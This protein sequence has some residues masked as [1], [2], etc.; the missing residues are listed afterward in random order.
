MNFYQKA[1]PQRRYAIRKTSA[2]VGSVLIGFFFLAGNMQSV[3]AA[4]QEVEA[5]T[6]LV[7]Q[8]STAEEPSSFESK[9]SEA[10]T[11]QLNSE[12]VNSKIPVSENTLDKENTIAITENPQLDSLGSEE[13]KKAI[14]ET[15]APNYYE[16]ERYQL[17]QTEVLVKKDEKVQLKLTNITTNEEVKEIN[18]YVRTD[19]PQTEVYN[20]EETIIGEDKK[21]LLRL[22][23]DGTVTSLNTH[24]KSQTVELW[25]EHNKHLYRA[26]VK[27]PG[28]EEMEA[29]QQ[30]RK[31]NAKADEIVKA[32]ENLSDVEKAKAAHDWLVDNVQYVDRPGKDQSA[33][34]ALVENKTVCAGYA[35]AF[36]LLMD[37]MGIPCHTKQGGIV[38]SQNHLW[39]M[40][41]LD[42][43]WYHVDAT[44]DDLGHTHLN[45]HR[46]EYFL[47]SDKDF[48][49]T[50]VVKRK[51]HKAHEDN[52]GE[53]YRFYGFEHEGLLKDKN[54]KVVKQGV[55]AKNIEEVSE[56][57]ER[58]YHKIAFKETSAV[59]ELLVPSSEPEANIHSRLA[60]ILT[61]TRFE[62]QKTSYGDYIFYRFNVKLYPRWNDR[63]NEPELKIDSLEANAPD[64]TEKMSSVLV[65][66][67][68]SVELSKSNFTVTGARLSEV[69]KVGNNGKVYR[70]KL[71]TPRTIV[72]GDVEISVNKRGYHREQAPSK[73]A[74]QVNR[75]SIPS[76]SFKAMGE[77]EGMLINV[78]SGME[79]RLNYGAWK[80]ISS[81]SV[82]LNNIG[83]AD[84][85][86]RVAETKN[87]Y[88]SPVQRLIVQKNSNVKASSKD[89]KIIG[90]NRSM[91]YR[92]KN[93]NQWFDCQGNCIT[94]LVNGEYEIRTKANANYLA[95]EITIVNLTN[96]VAETEEALAKQQAKAQEIQRKAEE[97]QAKREQKNLAQE[98]KSKQTERTRKKRH[99]ESEQQTVEAQKQNNELAKAKAAEKVTETKW[100]QGVNVEDHEFV[101]ITETDKD[102]E[103]FVTKQSAG[104]GWYD[105]NKNGH[106][107][108]DLCAGAVA[109]NMLHWW[110]D[111][112]KDYIERYLRENNNNGT[113]TIQ[114][115]KF[116]FRE[117]RQVYTGDNGYRDQ[118]RFFDI[119]KQAFP[120]SSVWTNKILD[121]YINGY[122]Y[123]QSS[124]MQNPP[125]E[126]EKLTS[127]INFFRNVFGGTPL[128]NYERVHDHDQ[129]SQSIKTALEQG[130]AIGVAYYHNPDATGHIVTAWGA[131]FD[132]SGKV[133][134]IYVSD[135]DDGGE[136]VPGEANGQVGLRRYRVEEHEG[137]LKLTS[138][139]QK[140]FGSYIGFI[141]TLSQGTE[142]WKEYFKDEE[143]KT[144]KLV[145]PEEA[146]AKPE[147]SEMDILRAEAERKAQEEQAKR[148]RA[149]AEEKARQEEAKRKQEEIAKQAKA[150][151]E[152]ERKAQEEQARRDR[153]LAEEQAKR[154]QEEKAKQVE[155]QRQAEAER[156]AE[157]ERQAEAQRQAEV[158]RKAQEEQAKREQEEKA[159]QVEAKRQAEAKRKAQEEQAQRDRAFAEEKARQEQVK[160]EQEEKAKQVE[161]QRQAEAERKT[162]EE[163][164]KRDRA[165]AEEKTRQEEAKRKQEEIAKQAEA[166]RKAQEE[167]AKREAE[168]KAKEEKAKRN[169]TVASKVKV[170]RK[171]TPMKLAEI[172]NGLQEVQ[173]ENLTRQG[174]RVIDRLES[175]IN[176]K[177]LSNVESRLTAESKQKDP[178]VLL[179]A[180]VITSQ[181]SA[182][183]QALVEDKPEEVTLRTIDKNLE[184]TD[185]KTE[186]IEKIPEKTPKST[187]GVSQ[188]V[189]K[190]SQKKTRNG[191]GS[192]AGFIIPTILVG[193]LLFTMVYLRRGNKRNR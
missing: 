171:H 189:E 28:T 170:N 31:A 165:L 149:L 53:N 12:D 7:S 118:S 65:T 21:E 58:Q 77:N 2:C 138:H 136:P 44:W 150:Q 123:T 142:A 104:Q 160:R 4:E 38:G 157:A 102:V 33:Y 89:G 184:G 70:L 154:E 52:M 174:D 131:D 87:T 94:G 40:I 3:Q 173:N 166:E 23:K 82:T 97:Q 18:W 11:T 144:G 147:F 107:D 81:N 73:V 55:L 164:A 122:G 111:Q 96:S 86:V 110:V 60:N 180:P 161:A 156:K 152:A 83:L 177:D 112:N 61:H 26:L 158:D 5:S 88:A 45:Y 168:R 133:I 13:V 35:K 1:D 32:F 19:Y 79:Y 99:T 163:Q 145:A 64:N 85:D 24:E 105:I 90:V 9:L 167:Q 57:L 172:D 66:L 169:Q 69:T 42:G 67:N 139:H 148:D 74:V 121:L 29:I 6:T 182:V 109:T 49:P 137:K 63:K 34:S 14:L 22:D 151:R 134:A 100:V 190:L 51:Y 135:S 41:E 175:S 59:L 91:E 162:Q 20:S 68:T 47:I 159:K 119:V 46:Y 117:A 153:V 181:Q 115:K 62:T 39:N 114:N 50:T 43:K 155:A 27:L 54:G 10:V 8:Q 48:N 95:S 116:D 146:P 75:A 127:Q 126:K 178:Q 103:Y 143:T 36:K 129:F 186:Q 132:D 192:T 17:S 124:N 15:P 113:Y 80:K 176:A 76:A 101:K 92:R 140:G 183:T 128:T 71:D 25:A 16:D 130:K 106:D 185:K 37:K 187:Q 30:D 193:I 120:H 188:R 84:I 125:V 141:N 179:L 108:G 72:G 56:V 98:D 78:D 93:T 191:Q